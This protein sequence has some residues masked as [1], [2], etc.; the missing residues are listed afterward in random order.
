MSKQTIALACILKNEARNLPRMLES[1][2]G[3]FDEIHLTDTGSTDGSIEMIQKWIDQ[4]HDFGGKMF[5]HHFEW[6]DDFAVARNASFAPVKTDYVMWMDLDDVLGNREAFLEWREVG[7]KLA[8]FHLATYHYSLDANGKPLCSFTRERVVRNGLGLKWKYFLHEGI[9]PESSGRVL[10]VA[11]AQTWHIKHLRDAEDLKADKSRNLRIFEKQGKLDSRMRYYYG[12]ELAENG[13]PLE[14]FGELIKAVAEPDLQHHDRVMGLQYAA[15]AAMQLNQFERAIQLAHQGLQL[16][17]NR[18]EFLIVIADSYLKSGKV[19]EAVPYYAAASSCPYTGAA[20]VQ[21]PTFS[22]EDSYKHYPLNQLARIYANM[23]DLD[24]AESFVNKALDHGPSTESMGILQD[25]QTVRE[26][27][28]MK[29][30]GLRKVTDDVV[31]TCPPQ[32]LYEWDWQ[33]YQEK[34]IGGS[35]TAACEMAKWISE[36]T[37]RKVIIFTPRKDTTVYG[38]FEFRPAAE[39][40]EYFRDTQPALHVAWRHCTRFN[41]EP[42]YVWC[43]DLAAMGM[44]Q[45]K[46]DKILALSPFH[47]GFLKSMHG[48]AEEKIHV[49]GNG[50]DPNRFLGAA[51]VTKKA[52]KVVFS[53]SP[54]RGLEA[55][56]KVMDEVVKTNPDAELHV[57]YGFE[58]MMKMGMQSQAA[59]LQAMMGAR[60][61]VKF[62]GNVPQ[63]KLTEEIADAAVWLYPTNFLET[64]CI[65]AVEMLCSGVFPVVRDW[66]AL[67]DTLGAAA[68]QGMA[69]LV[70]AD[71]S[72]LEGISIF[73]DEVRK[74][75][76]EKSWEKVTVDPRTFSWENVAKSWI[77]YF[78][79]EAKCQRSSSM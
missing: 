71:P 18:A 21:G 27:T 46:F 63:K 62:H 40:P 25:L 77:D 38:G 29:P 19:V 2:R 76:N 17:P 74:A 72:S 60:P 24:R 32:G 3:C 69:K 54:D 4:G 39:A 35:E 30:A 28:T 7:M 11:Y 15:M 59:S 6:C 37:G 20:P 31:I 36:L 34:G 22:H 55:A 53:S 67:P 64:Y 8:D 9:L 45:Q 10:G 70:D 79:L 49:T 26:K 51:K 58:N 12:K 68:G 47:K 73:A 5:L 78:G 50:I 56:M 1:I 14:G 33:A 75:L 16:A 48:I 44:E 43:H 13:K 42:L 66:G 57:Y 52:N 23:G 61:Y 41:E 65:T